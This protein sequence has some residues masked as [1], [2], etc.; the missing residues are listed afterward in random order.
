MTIRIK[1]RHPALKHAGYSAT[2]VLPGENPVEFEKLHE[3]LISEFTPNGAL[4]DETVASMAHL[5]W[6]RKNLATF[7]IAE[8]AQQRMTQIRDVIVPMDYGMPKPDKSDDFDKTF[9]EKWRAAEDQA[10]EELGELYGLVEV[11]EEATVDCLIR[12]L[13][14]QER[15]DAM[16]DKCLKRL[17]FLRG[18]KSISA[19]SSSSPPQRLAGPSKAA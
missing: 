3:E 11:G 2:G 14:V 12:D 6:R 8:R 15:L 4:E 16:I 7:R 13:V 1:K 19:A 10:R 9:S 17:L 18:L 5:L